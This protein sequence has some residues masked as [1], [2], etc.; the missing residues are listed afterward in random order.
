VGSC[1]SARSTAFAGLAPPDPC[2]SLPSVFDVRIV[3][4][5][6]APSLRRLMAGSDRGFDRARRATPKC[7]RFRAIPIAPDSVPAALRTTPR[8]RSRARLDRSRDRCE[9]RR[10]HRTIRPLALDFPANSTIHNG[11]S[12]PV[13]DL[14]S[15]NSGQTSR[16]TGPSVPSSVANDRWIFPREALGPWS[17]S[18]RTMTCLKGPAAMGRNSSRHRSGASSSGACLRAA[19]RPCAGLPHAA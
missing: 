4:R 11:G 18:P 17:W 12:P 2:G 13:G 16:S 9:Q 10:G 6:S 5:P 14:P 15:A 7:R 3:R 1:S 19:F 8:F